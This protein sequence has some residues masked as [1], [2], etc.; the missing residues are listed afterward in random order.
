MTSSKRLLTV[1]RNNLTNNIWFTEEYM[2]GVSLEGSSG[3]LRYFAG[4][5]SSGPSTPELGDY[6]AGEFYLGTLGYDLADGTG[7]DEALLRLNL[8]YNEPHEENSSTRDLER[9]ASLNFQYQRG[10]WGLRTDL[11]A[12]R[13]YFEQP[14]L[15]GFVVMP[16][17]ELT[18]RWQ[19]VARYT[20]VD[21]AGDNGVRLSRYETSIED[22]RGDRY[23]EIHVGLSYYWYG[24]KLKLQ[25]G[26]QWVDMRDQ[27]D[28]GGAYRGWSWTT[29]FRIS[30]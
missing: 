3:S 12:A 14:D 28:D 21:S 25:N 15:W 9:I 23:N 5:F 30:W 16:Y 11:S 4:L 8:V 13:G 17:R 6:S 26:L 20:F 1:E 24:H 29:G 27:A 10:D 19:I 7:A 18:D 22:G 2:P